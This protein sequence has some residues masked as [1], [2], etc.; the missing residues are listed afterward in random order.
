M[1]KIISILCV[2]LFLF[3][4]AGFYIAFNIDQFII[5]E[6]IRRKLMFDI[7]VNELA[8]I[9]INNNSKTK[10]SW[11]DGN[12][13]FSY[14]HKMYDVVRMQ[15]NDTT[16]IYYCIEDNKENQ[17]N[18]KLEEHVVNNI[19][20]D[21]IQKANS[22]NVIKKIATDEFF[23][24]NSVSIS[25]SESFKIEFTTL[26]MTYKPVYLEIIKPPPIYCHTV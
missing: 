25:S 21:P 9:T 2:S 16:T 13:E 22:S 24:A 12:K 20:N 6:E 14:N 8:V 18:K 23:F 4:Y 11:Y 5:K 10:L 1:R 26:F 3:N 19:S 17:L 7:P 15:N